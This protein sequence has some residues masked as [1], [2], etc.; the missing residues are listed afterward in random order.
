MN[1]GFSRKIKEEVR[2]NGARVTRYF[3]W[4]GQSQSQAPISNISSHLV[5][6]KLFRNC[7]NWG[8]FFVA[9]WLRIYASTI[10]GPVS[11][12]TRGIKILH[13]TWYG[14]K[15]KKKLWKLRPREAN[16]LEEGH[17]SRRPDFHP[18][19]LYYHDGLRSWRFCQTPYVCTAKREVNESVRRVGGSVFIVN[20]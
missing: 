10:G 5:P 16:N 2:R 9:Q 3:T 7:E 12:P 1:H 18:Q 14:Q 8:T 11:I 15:T 17:R 20:A 6:R 4:V 19:C 13:A